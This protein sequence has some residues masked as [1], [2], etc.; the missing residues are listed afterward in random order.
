VVR[1][2]SQDG[3]GK[4]GRVWR[5]RLL[6]A[7]L[8]LSG[9]ELLLWLDPPARPI[10]AWPLLAVGYFLLSALL[11]D[12]ATRFRVRSIFGLLA[13]AGIGA[14]LN[15]L[16]I[17]PTYALA[18]VPRTLLTRVL[19]ATAFV[20]LLMLALY[21]VLI[22]RLRLRW[23]LLL[24]MPLLGLGWGT[25]AHW[26]PTLLDAR[27][28]PAP[29][30]LL[31]LWLGGAAALIGLLAQRTNR[32]ANGAALNLRMTRAEWAISAAVAAIVLIMRSAGDRVPNSEDGLGLA[33]GALIITLL[34][35]AYCA[36]ILWFQRRKK[37]GSLFDPAAQFRSSRLWLAAG[38]AGFVIA[39]VV[40]YG[41]PR[42][43]GAADPVFVITNI[44]T[45]F[46]ITWLPAVSLTLGAQSF[47]RL[48]RMNRL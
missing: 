5:L 3:I 16:L 39:A 20:T 48:A 11:L 26:S 31:L 2:V 38:F 25:W 46:G 41:L 19:G 33:A 8:L 1:S 44:W 34:L 21:L 14:L 43:E 30:P 7:A 35:S 23:G 24:T 27:G 22:G 6:L 36:L 17:N 47:A 15:A 4:Q 40:G 42:G 28:E 45:G 32:A 9:V 10:Y 29:L 12:L 13:L 37:G 18:E